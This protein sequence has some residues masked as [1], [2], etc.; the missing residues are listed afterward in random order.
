MDVRIGVF[1]PGLKGLLQERNAA[2]AVIITAFN[3][4]GL[5]RE[6][7]ANLLAQRGLEQR[8]RQQGLGP[9][10]PTLHL[11]PAGHWPAEEGLLV[12]GLGLRDGLA[13]AADFGQNAIV[14]TRQD[15]V[16]VLAAT[17]RRGDS[18]AATL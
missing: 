15:G 17:A 3:P 8:L 4:A 11:D 16:P 10:L 14:F 12:P 5:R 7:E 13:L 2:S 18:G 9:G 1:C 6:R